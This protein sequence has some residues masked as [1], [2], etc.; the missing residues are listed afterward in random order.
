MDP[1]KGTTRTLSGDGGFQ[2]LHSASEGLSRGRISSLT[3]EVHMAKGMTSL[4][5]EMALVAFQFG[6]IKELS[7]SRTLS[8]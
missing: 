1:L 7:F 3:Q 8:S 5:C 6:T 4:S 2:V